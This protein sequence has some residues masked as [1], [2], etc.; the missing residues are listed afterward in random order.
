MHNAG[1]LLDEE[2]LASQPLMPVLEDSLASS[3]DESWA[4]MNVLSVEICCCT[5]IAI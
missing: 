1:S 2:S 4:N 3:S 5:S